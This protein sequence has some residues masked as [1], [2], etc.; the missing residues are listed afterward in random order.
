MGAFFFYAGRTLGGLY[1]TYPPRPFFL[2]KILIKKC[3]L[4]ESSPYNLFSYSAQLIL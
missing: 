2:E 4:D 1:R 3:G